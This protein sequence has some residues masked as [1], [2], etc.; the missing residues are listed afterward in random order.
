MSAHNKEGE[1]VE[2]TM[3]ESERAAAEP[4]TP[5]LGSVENPGVS[6]APTRRLYL[7]NPSNPM[8]SILDVKESRWNR[9][10]VWKPLGLMVIAGLTP[11]DWEVTII[12]ENL[13]V[14]D[15]SGL[16]RPDLVGVT[17]FTSQAERAYALATH[18]RDEG[19]SVVIGGIHAT[20]CLEEASSYVD[21]VVTGEAEKVWKRVLKDARSDQLK[22]L[23]EG[24]LAEMSELSPARHDLLPNEYAFGS[25]QTTRGCPLHCSFCSVTAFNGSRFRQRPIEDVIRELEALSEDLVLIVDDNL[26]GTRHQHQERAKDLFRAMIEANLDK[27]WVAQATINIANDDELL[28]LAAAAGCKGLFVGFES[29]QPETSK[30]IHAKNNLC[31]CRDLSYAVRRIQN[32]GILVAGSFIIGLEG[33]RPGV[34]ALIADTAERYGVDFVNALFLTPLPGTKLWDEMKAEAR[35]TP[36]QFPGDWSYFTLTY[37]VARFAGL[38]S[39]QAVTEMISCSKRFYSIPRMLRRLWRNLWR[40]QPVRIGLAGGL[41]YRHNI[42]I[43]QAKLEAFLARHGNDMDTFKDRS[44]EPVANHSPHD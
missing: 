39:R 35:V 12:D 42:P 40:G 17:A 10:R 24:G 29:P 26:I 8:V 6:P 20:M 25:V 32:H 44:V 31:R 41:S 16:P 36:S 33:D 15:Y 9:C 34:G 22:P 28:S 2:R 14:P 21:A 4:Q 7:I 27:S 30:E 5:A 1:K 38:T 13:G 18:F 11:R 19:V 37:P 23:Y 3:N 43:E